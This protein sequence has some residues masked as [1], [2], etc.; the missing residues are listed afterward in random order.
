MK[1]KP[2]L[3]VIAAAILSGSSGVFIKNIEMAATSLG[4]IRSLL[5]VILMAGIMFYKGIPLF[6][7]NYRLMMGASAL[8]ALRL[9]LFITAYTYTNIGNAVIIQFTW[10][11]FVTIF[12]VIFLGESTS[13]RNIFLLILAFVG[14]VIIYAGQDLS[15]ANDDFLGMTAALGTAICHAI[16]IVIFK[17]ESVN[18]S[19]YELLFYQN[20][21][22]ILLFLPFFII[23]PFPTGQD[24]A[25]ASVYSLLLGTFGFAL[26]LYGLTYL[27]ASVASA[28]AYIEIISAMFFAVVILGEPV[29]LN[30]GLGG[31]LVIVSTIFLNRIKMAVQ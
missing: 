5:P 24:I 25:I 28:I 26:F 21:L 27:K 8:N 11:V 3:A 7:G 15:F 1:N 14:I 10:P 22:G 18:Y 2:F 6:R 9:F 4:F 29:T 20:L 13:L 19:R 30:M 12:S 17:K 23:A 31:G 16:G